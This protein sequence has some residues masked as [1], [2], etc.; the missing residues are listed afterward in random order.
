M[1]DFVTVAQ[2]DEIPP[3]ERLVVEMGR[4][5]VV[6][7]NVDGTLYAL[8]DQCSH[9]EYPLSDGFIDGCEVECAKHGARFDL[10]TGKNTAPPALVPVRAY[11]VRVL[12]DEVQIARR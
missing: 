11:D 6:I 10:R 3:G 5:W 8:E 4:S 9:E 7:F 1:A 12:G 2:V